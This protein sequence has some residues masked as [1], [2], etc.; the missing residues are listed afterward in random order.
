M[1]IDNVK[2]MSN[3]EIDTILKSCYGEDLGYNSDDAEY[4]YYSKLKDGKPIA[5]IHQ[6][7]LVAAGIFTTSS[8]GLWLP[9]QSLEIYS[10]THLMTTLEIHDHYSPSPSPP[11]TTT[12]TFDF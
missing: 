2:S 7:G 9:F 12:H 11:P 5:G 3:E 8:S 6:D 10:H 1:V 4:E